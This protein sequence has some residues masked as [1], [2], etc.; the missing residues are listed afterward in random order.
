MQLGEDFKIGLKKAMINDSSI[1]IED[2][3]KNVDMYR[4]VV[5][6]Q[7]KIYEIEERR[8]IMLDEM[9]WCSISQESEF[10]EDGYKL[11]LEEMTMR[12]Q[13]KR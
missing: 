7:A 1:T 12:S 2:A 8:N 13:V 10:D 4:D 9:N 6:A 11:L 5:Q 3:N